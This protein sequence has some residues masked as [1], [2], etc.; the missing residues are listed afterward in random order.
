MP[1]KPDMPISDPM[2]S[3]V[4]SVTY[5]KSEFASGIITGRSDDTTIKAA[6]V[7]P[8]QIPCSV[9]NGAR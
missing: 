4:E 9:P 8:L 7:A 3:F 6:Q 1:F 5:V 2:K